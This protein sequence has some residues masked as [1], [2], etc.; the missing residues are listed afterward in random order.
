MFYP[1]L[2]DKDMLQT[3]RSLLWEPGG[4]TQQGRRLPQ[5]SPAMTPNCKHTQENHPPKL[6]HCFCTSAQVSPSSPF[7]KER[8]KE[9]S[10]HTDQWVTGEVLPGTVVLS[11]LQTGKW[12]QCSFPSHTVLLA[13]ELGLFVEDPRDV[14]AST[15]PPTLPVVLGTSL[16]GIH[17]PYMHC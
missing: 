15:H 12:Q 3:S 7:K 13:C 2:P 11:T 8:K 5:F 16:L 9:K 14:H 6:T 1:A 4:T 17:S 10:V